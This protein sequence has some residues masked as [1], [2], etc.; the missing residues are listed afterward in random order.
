MTKALL[1][2]AGPLVLGFLLDQLLGDP[3]RLYHPVRLMGKLIRRGEGYLRGK[4]PGTPDALR[5]AGLQLAAFCACAAFLCY[6]LLGIV[7]LRVWGE[8]ALFGVETWVCYRMLAAGELRRSAARVRRA[9]ERDGL[10]A[11]EQALS[12]IVGRDTD[13]LDESGVVR[14]AVETVAEN[15]CDGVVAPMLYLAFGLPLG[16]AYKMVNT[17][18]SMVGYQNERYLEFGRA[19]ARLDDFANWLPARLSAVLMIGASALCGYSPG[20]AW[21]IWRRDRLAHKSPNSAQTESVC[22][23][24]LGLRLGGPSRYGGVPVGKPYLG[25]DTRPA[26]PADI[27]RAGRLMT[28]T[29]ALALPLCVGLRLLFLLIIRQR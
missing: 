22:A 16:A 17:L 14:A 11:A 13:S 1:L 23:G 8:W 12:M 15:T 6:Q 21:R 2:A 26:A 4:I 29:A 7:V 28:V 20:A 24:A 9:L 5:A 3:P 27:R 19:S 25:D 18:D 10:A